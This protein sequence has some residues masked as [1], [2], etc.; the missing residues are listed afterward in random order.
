MKLWESSR[1]F[2]VFHASSI[3][4]WEQVSDAKCKDM[5]RH[6][7]IVAVNLISEFD[8]HVVGTKYKLSTTK[9]VVES[10][11]D[12]MGLPIGDFWN[13]VQIQVNRKGEGRS[14]DCAM[15]FQNVPVLFGLG[16]ELCRKTKSSLRSETCSRLFASS[17][18]RQGHLWRVQTEMFLLRGVD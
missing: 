6:L 9:A 14:L 12:E 16:W 7:R 11:P 15:T 13:F 1:T 5:V 18:Q 8:F 4:L 2:E 17:A 10:R 3:L